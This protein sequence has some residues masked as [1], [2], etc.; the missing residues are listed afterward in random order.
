M[1]AEGWSVAHSIK[2]PGNRLDQGTVECS[3]PTLRTTFR[4]SA[5]D[6]GTSERPA[7]DG[8]ETAQADHNYPELTRRLLLG[9][10]WSSGTSKEPAAA[11]EAM[12]TDRR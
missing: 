1:P 5:P 8:S 3:R 2:Q 7:S 4:A 11:T 12:K 10:G 9:V 6:L